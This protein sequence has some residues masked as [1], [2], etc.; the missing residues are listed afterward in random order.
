MALQPP[1]GENVKEVV[2]TAASYWE[3]LSRMI[4]VTIVGG[5]VGFATNLMRIA[6]EPT[7]WGRLLMCISVVSV[8]CV[9]AGA[10]VLGTTLFLDNPTVEVELLIASIAGASGQKMFDIY[11]RRIFGVQGTRHTDKRPGEGE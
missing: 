4:P 10:S 11:A 1:D 6:H 2:K 3:V 8:G 9:A 5:L 7:L